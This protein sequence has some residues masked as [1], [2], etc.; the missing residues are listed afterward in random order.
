MDSMSLD[1]TI[2]IGLSIGII[3]YITLYIGKGIQKYAIEGFKIDRT[4]KSKHSGIWIFGTV[5]TAL[6]MFIHW[7]A[8]SFAPIN[9]IAPLEGTGLVALVFFSYYILKESIT[10]TEISGV[11]LIIF[12][13]ILAT[14]YNTNAGEVEALNLRINMF[15]LLSIP[16][17]ST[18]II[19]IIISKF[20]G[21]KF[22]GLIIG[23]TAGTMMALQTLTKRISF[24]QGYTLIFSALVLVF[25]TATLAVT[26]FAFAKAKA[27]QVVPC[28][29][30]A[31]II[32]AILAGKTVLNELL[33]TMQISGIIIILIGVILLTAF[34]KGE[35]SNEVFE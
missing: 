28:F 2:I 13:T 32:I 24:I 11:V 19:L 26:Q 9:L 18:E 14:L 6:F 5:L 1:K 17:V 20:N 30:S 35:K 27:N 3:S 10:K 8:L 33:V 15:L 7:G 22:S 16:I 34:P 4:I 23:S 29:T 21:Y 25:A 12:G 31:S